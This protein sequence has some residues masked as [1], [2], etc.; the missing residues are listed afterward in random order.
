[1]EVYRTKIFEDDFTELPKTVRH[2]FE[3]ELGIFLNNPLHPSLR[4]KKMAGTDDIWEVRITKGYRFT[5]TLQNHL[6]ILRRI[7]SHDILRN[8]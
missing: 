4:C 7:G 2:R 5:F 3:V 8:P 1:M 6:C